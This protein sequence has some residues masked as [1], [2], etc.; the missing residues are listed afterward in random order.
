MV[1][2]P[3]L[4]DTQLLLLLRKDRCSWRVPAAKGG[5]AT[6]QHTQTEREFSVT[7]CNAME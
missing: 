6:L 5:R 3:A 1:D 2:S 4:P 7:S